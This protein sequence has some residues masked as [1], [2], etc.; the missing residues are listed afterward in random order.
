MI[1]LRN[2]VW[3]P[4][5]LVQ[6]SGQMSHSITG[7]VKIMYSDPHYFWSCNFI[8]F[9]YLQAFAKQMDLLLPKYNQ[10]KGRTMSRP[11]SFLARQL[12]VNN[13]GHVL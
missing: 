5:T 10:R 3:I 11:K 6:Y 2:I 7:L 12:Q 4:E 9:F 13:S 8:S 1:N